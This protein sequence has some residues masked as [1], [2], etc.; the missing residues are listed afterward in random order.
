MKILVLG[1]S[2]FLG[3]AFVEEALKRNHQVSVFNRGSQNGALENVE[4]IIGDRFGELDPLKGRVWDAVLDTSGYVPSTVRKSTE[5]LGGNTAH[6]T[7]ISSISVYKDWG[8][9]NMDESGPLLEMD[10]ERADELSNGVN[11]PLMEYY[12]EFKTLCEH[13]A[14]KNMPG[15]VLNVRAGLL[16]GPDDY[17][18][19]FTYWVNRVARGG[20]VLAPGNP[21]RRIQFIDSRDL[22]KW[23]LFMIEQNQ[24]GTYNATGPKQPLEM[25]AFLQ[26]I[27]KVTGSDAEFD[28][29]DESF[30]LERKIA[31]WTEMPLWLPEEPA[32][33]DKPL[34]GAFSFNI[35]RALKAGLSFSPLEKTIEDTYLWDQ[36]RNG[37]N[38]KAGLSF[39]KE[40]QLINEW[41][42]KR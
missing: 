40:Q 22:A 18:D 42:N 13:E 3:K 36:S 1:G 25:G 34:K 30:L 35:E 12:G 7:F 19:R 17:S 11:G 16:V 2:R 29:V 32:A 23:I 31:P 33:G 5:V 24:S 9:Q 10:P 26:A 38:L 21:K 41:N 6:Y 15:R 20:K 37:E 27:K 39:E 8:I 28:W 14:E 4:V